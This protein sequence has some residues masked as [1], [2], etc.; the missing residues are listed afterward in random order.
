MLAAVLH[1]FNDLRLEQ[2]SVPRATKQ[3]TIVVKIHSCGICCRTP[4]PPFLEP[5]MKP[6]VPNSLTL[7]S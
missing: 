1:N 5:R 2:V 6:P 4:Q 3:G 7:R